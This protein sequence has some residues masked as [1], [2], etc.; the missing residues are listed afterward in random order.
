MLS[1]VVAVVEGLEL[2]KS[3]EEKKKQ[4]KCAEEGMN[5]YRIVHEDVLWRAISAIIPSLA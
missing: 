4:T 1:F 2:P 3:F 5:G